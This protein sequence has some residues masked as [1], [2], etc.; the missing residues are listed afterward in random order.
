MNTKA[1]KIALLKDISAGLIEPAAISA[2]SI[3]C[4]Q[5]NE[6]FQGMMMAPDAPVIFV[7][8]ARKA[9]DELMQSSD[10]DHKAI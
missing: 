7:G 5:E 6:M 8:K 2:G 10:I 3:I 4:S 9:L 1:D